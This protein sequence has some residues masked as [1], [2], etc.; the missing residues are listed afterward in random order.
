MKRILLIC[1]ML[2]I[3]SSLMY[4][5]DIATYVDLGFSS[6]A[7]YY[8]FAQYG[9]NEQTLPYAEIYTVNVGTNRFVDGGVLSETYPVTVNPG[10]E[11]LGAL[12]SLMRKGTE[13]AKRYGIDH[14]KTGRLVYVLLNGEKPKENIQFR[15]FQTGNH[16]SITLKQSSFG[17]GAGVSSSFYIDVRIEGSGGKVEQHTV[18]LPEYKRPGVKGYTIRRILISPQDNALIFIIEKTETGKSGSNIRYMV[19]TLPLF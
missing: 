16:F 8:M 13:A 12:F 10:Q 9:I 11:G 19:E 18:G 5:G 17:E 7:K 14:L 4:A 3:A 1:I 6:D 2:F 15:D